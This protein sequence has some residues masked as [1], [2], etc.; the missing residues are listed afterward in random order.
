MV[1]HYGMSKAVGVVAHDYEDAGKSV[2]TYTRRVIEAEVKELL[3]TAYS[4]AKRI[5]TLHNNQLHTLAQELLDKETL[6]GAQIKALL[7]N[8]APAPA[9]VPASVPASAPAPAY[10][11]ASA[12]AAAV[13]AAQA[14][15]TAA[16]AA[17]AGATRSSKSGSTRGSTTQAAGG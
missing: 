3:E 17:T 1:T 15:A 4:N 13:A 7:A 9:S 2:S 14:A 11:P 16:T 5:L 8:P 12:A 10:T 6:T